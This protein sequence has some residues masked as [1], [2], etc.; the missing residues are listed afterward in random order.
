[1]EEPLDR[2]EEWRNFT[3]MRCTNCNPEVPIF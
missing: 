2:V 3:W 1:M